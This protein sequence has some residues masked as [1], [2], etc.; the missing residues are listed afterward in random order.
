[1]GLQIS[2]IDYRAFTN[3]PV[4]AFTPLYSASLADGRSAVQRIS[5]QQLYAASVPV[6]ASTGE[7]IALV[8]ASLPTAAIDQSA[9]HLTHKLLLT[10]LV[11]ASLAVFGGLVL[12][13]LGGRSGQGA[14]ERGAAPG[15]GRFLNIDS[16]RRRGRSGG[17]RAHH[18]GHATQPRGAH[19]HAAATRSGGPGRSQRRRRRSLCRRQGS[20]DP[21]PQPAG[22][23]S[24]WRHTQGGRGTLLRRCAETA[25]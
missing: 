10:A 5:S 3:D 15:P 12:N 16:T 14:D 6:F 23:S 18:G 19:R 17:A 8:L 22:G 1:M 13:E 11:L 20:R 4:N 2:L 7:A 24:A 9:T 25:R 21:L